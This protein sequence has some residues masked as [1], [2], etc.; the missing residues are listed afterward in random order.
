MS[1]MKIKK[2]TDEPK[3][4]PILS[5]ALAIGALLIIA[6][7][8]YLV[9]PKDQIDPN[10]VPEV[11][12]APRLKVDKERVDLGDVKFGKTVYATFMLTNVGDKVLYLT[13]NP[14]IELIEGC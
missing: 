6:A 9:S 10:F 12:G 11:I 7:G 1:R 4:T 2:K 5:I 13:E 8:Y 3:N 14:S